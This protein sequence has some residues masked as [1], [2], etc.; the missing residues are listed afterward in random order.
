MPLQFKDLSE[1]KH[2]NSVKTSPPLSHLRYDRLIYAYCKCYCYQEKK[3][4]V[5]ETEMVG[6]KMMSLGLEQRL[7]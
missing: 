7:D 6:R 1:K 2:A 5:M 3:K 4:N